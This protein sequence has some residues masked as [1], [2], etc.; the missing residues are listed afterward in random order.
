M[1]VGLVCWNIYLSVYVT[2]WDQKKTKR[3]KGSNLMSCINVWCKLHNI[4][5]NVTI[6]ECQFKMGWPME[7]KC[8][9]QNM[10][11]IVLSFF[12]YWIQPQARNYLNQ[13]WE[14]ET[15]PW[16]RSFLASNYTLDMNVGYMNHIQSMGSIMAIIWWENWLRISRPVF[17]VMRKM[18]KVRDGTYPKWTP[19]LTC[20]ET[21]QSLEQQETSP[22]RLENKH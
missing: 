21:C 20:H 8:A 17:N 13:D 10:L 16:K 7:Q 3:R 14:A 1:L 19:L 4:R 2:G 5:V 22:E 11:E 12:V 15:F 6:H 9:S 18:G